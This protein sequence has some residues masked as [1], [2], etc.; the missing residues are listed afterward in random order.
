MFF[1]LSREATI[2]GWTW[3][4]QLGHASPEWVCGQWDP[5]QGLGGAKVWLDGYWELGL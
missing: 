5:T 2:C 4:P 3:E 1:E